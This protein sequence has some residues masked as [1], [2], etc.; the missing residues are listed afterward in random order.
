MTKKIIKKVP[1]IESEHITKRARI[2]KRHSIELYDNKRNNKKTTEKDLT[3]DQKELYEYNQ[4][5]L[6]RRLKKLK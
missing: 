2:V 4:E 6:R 3:D 1:Q 5:K